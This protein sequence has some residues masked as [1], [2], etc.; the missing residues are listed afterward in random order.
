MTFSPNPNFSLELP[1]PEP[2]IEPNDMTIV[3]PPCHPNEPIKVPE[4]SLTRLHCL[5][6]AEPFAV[7]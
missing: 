6:C 7:V 2:L 5:I 1:P 3:E 4:E